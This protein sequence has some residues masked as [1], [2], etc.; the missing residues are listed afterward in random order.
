[1]LG[2]EERGA[3]PLASGLPMMHQLASE[4]PTPLSSDY[5]SRWGQTS[6]TGVLPLTRRGR[7]WVEGRCLV[8][9]YSERVGT[10][11]CHVWVQSV[12]FLVSVD[13]WSGGWKHAGGSWAEGGI[14]EMT[15]TNVGSE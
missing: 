1:M 5:T 7:G 8:G 9:G 11:V 4:E 10:S 6:Q 15:E 2:A 12:D 3:G 14:L 13:V